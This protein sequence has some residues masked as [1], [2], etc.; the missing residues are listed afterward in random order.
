[1]KFYVIFKWILLIDSWGIS[2]EIALIRMSLDFTVRQ[3]A[4]TWANVDPDLCRH[5]VSLGQNESNSTSVIDALH[6]SEFVLTKETPYLTLTGELW[7]VYCEEF[8]ENWLS[9]NGTALHM[10]YAL[11]FIKFYSFDGVQPK[12]LKHSGS[13]KMIAILETN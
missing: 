7:S 11:Q 12:H 2:C 9:Y 13:H 1:M 5:M 10:D 4:I 8:Q 3:Q 6:E